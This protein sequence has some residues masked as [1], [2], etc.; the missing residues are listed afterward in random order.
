MTK[1]INSILEEVLERVEPP[2]EELK[3]IN[4]SLD[5]FLEKIKKKIKNFENKCRSFCWR[6][7]LLRRL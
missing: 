1:K 2:K 4:D 5:D 6:K 3:I 7:F